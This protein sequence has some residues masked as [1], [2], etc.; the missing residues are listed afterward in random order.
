MS[1]V[2]VKK[3][4]GQFIAFTAGLLISFHANSQSAPSELGGMVIDGVVVMACADVAVSEGALAIQPGSELTEV[5]NLVIGPGGTLNLEGVLRLSGTYENQGVVTGAGR[6]EREAF[7]EYEACAR[8]VG[9]VGPIYP[10]VEP[11]PTISEW[12]LMILSVVMLML[13]VRRSCFARRRKMG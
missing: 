6:I 8:A 12:G 3:R 2:S 13:G 11:V 10:N 1:S 5:R 9:P 7:S 4:G